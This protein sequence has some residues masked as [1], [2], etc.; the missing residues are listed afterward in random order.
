MIAGGLSKVVPWVFCLDVSGC[1]DRPIAFSRNPVRYSR[2]R[3][4]DVLTTAV[5]PVTIK[6]HT[7]TGLLVRTLVRDEALNGEPVTWDFKNDDG[8]LVASGLYIVS[9]N[10]DG[11]IYREKLLFVK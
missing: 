10:V 11:K 8:D 7:M 5:G 9:A 1:A 6:I 4:V 2:E 3:T